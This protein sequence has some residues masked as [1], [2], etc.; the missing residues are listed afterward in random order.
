MDAF[1][2]HRNSEGLILHITATKMK[3][4]ELAD[5]M[6]FMKKTKTGIMRSFSVA[7]LDDF[8]TDGK[9]DLFTLISIQT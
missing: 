8:I 4:L 5:E 6:A 3:L 9:L 7:C 1:I 2:I